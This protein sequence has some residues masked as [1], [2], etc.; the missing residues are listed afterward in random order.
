MARLG[1][2][3]PS[4]RPSQARAPLRCVWVNRSVVG[5]RKVGF[6]GR[7]VYEHTSMSQR[8]ADDAASPVE[9]AV[10]VFAVDDEELVTDLIAAILGAEGYVV[11]V[12]QHPARALQAFTEASPKPDLLIT[13]F[14]MGETN[15]IELI[16]QCR[17]QA[18]SLPTL[19]LSGTVTEDAIKR[20][21]TQPDRFLPKPFRAE[22]LIA[23]V[24]ELLAA[25]TG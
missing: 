4:M 5:R 8:T 10:R 23:V 24:R 12:F 9:T 18:P 17:R 11:Q 25:R 2:P 3:S 13:D 20:F 19:L 15:G 22:Q 7:A 14:V 6:N 16:E 21:A 1:W